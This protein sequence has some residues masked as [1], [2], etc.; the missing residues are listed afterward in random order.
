MPVSTAFVHITLNIDSYNLIFNSVQLR[1]SCGHVPW[2]L[3]GPESSRL[4][5]KSGGTCTILRISPFQD[6]DC[7]YN[8]ISG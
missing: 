7:V 4:F 6:D 1:L 8:N 5:V 2:L 3:T